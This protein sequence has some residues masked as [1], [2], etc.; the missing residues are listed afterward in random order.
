VFQIDPAVKA[1]RIV[2]AG[3]LQF[4]IAVGGD[5]LVAIDPVGGNVL[6][7][8]GA[9]RTY[10][11]AMAGKYAPDFP[12]I[13]VGGRFAMPDD[14]LDGAAGVV[15]LG[16]PA[17]FSTDDG[18]VSSSGSFG[19]GFV[20]ADASYEDVPDVDDE[21]AV[22]AG[23]AGPLFVL[24]DGSELYGGDVAIEPDAIDWRFPI[25]SQVWTIGGSAALFGEIDDISASEGGEVLVV[26][27]EMDSQDL[28]P[29]VYAFGGLSID[30]EGTGEA[31]AIVLQVPE[32]TADVACE[33]TP[34]TGEGLLCHVRGSDGSLST[35]RASVSADFDLTEIETD[36]EDDEFDDLSMAPS[37]RGF[38]T[39][40]LDS[41]SR[42]GDD[43][44][45]IYYEDGV[46]A[47]GIMDFVAPSE[48]TASADPFDSIDVA[49]LATDGG[50]IGDRAL[51]DTSI[52]LAA[53][54][55]G[56][57]YI[58]ELEGCGDPAPE[59]KAACED[60]GVLS[61]EHT[62]EGTLVIAAMFEGD[63]CMFDDC[64]NPLT[65]LDAT[66]GGAAANPPEFTVAPYDLPSDMPVRI[67]TWFP[68]DLGGVCP[69][70]GDAPGA[71]LRY[72]TLA[73]PIPT[74]AVRPMLVLAG[75][76]L[77]FDGSPQNNCGPLADQPCPPERLPM[78]HV[79]DS[80]CTPDAG[81][82]TFRV[83]NTDASYGPTRFVVRDGN[84]AG[85]LTLFDGD[86]DFMEM[87]DYMTKPVTPGETYAQVIV[88]AF[89]ATS[90]ATVAQWNGSATAGFGSYSV[91][92]DER[93]CGSLVYSR[94][95][96]TNQGEF[97]YLV[98]KPAL[99]TPYNGIA[100]PDVCL[101]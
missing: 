29:G 63:L 87:T 31:G 30:A 86:L 95:A 89:D 19:R 76:E 10:E 44:P 9:G 88:Q 5:G 91:V 67:S 50:L 36:A 79:V 80:T 32:G 12:E 3:G 62:R 35:L 97:A 2:T 77:A 82:G 68:F 56:Q 81:V 25:E 92:M 60:G 75:A 42:V 33:V 93:F 64:G 101:P 78:L 28:D 15:D 8:L 52:R 43:G 72:D 85:A 83:L 55:P 49:P 66:V 53:F 20:F 13:V 96:G 24:H 90:G 45:A 37:P 7:T 51:G 57:L 71:L 99:C 6:S 22:L 16:L 41:E 4:V 59:P 58:A 69:A 94:R 70:S 54:S 23:I 17:G 46:A 27:D 34:G 73:P 1:A 100:A 65:P 21:L 98:E 39:A 47:R 48:P 11:V 84:G 18:M 40:G 38:C 26:V 74:S 61:A 14:D